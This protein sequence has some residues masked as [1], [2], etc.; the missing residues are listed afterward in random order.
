MAAGDAL[1]EAVY[2]VAE[3]AAGQLQTPPPDRRAGR[4]GR[5]ARPAKVVRPGRGRGWRPR[6]GVSWV[7]RPGGHR[8]V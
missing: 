5:A 4:P 8:T 3:E 6:P 1:D 2:A 7:D